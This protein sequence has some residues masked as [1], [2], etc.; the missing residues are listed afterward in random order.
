MRLTSPTIKRSLNS[1]PDDN[2][3]FRQSAQSGSNPISNDPLN[4][5]PGLRPHTLPSGFPH[6]LGGTASHDEWGC[7]ASRHGS[8]RTTA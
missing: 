2:H 7:P 4:E 5:T 8:K 3:S 1:I 6:R